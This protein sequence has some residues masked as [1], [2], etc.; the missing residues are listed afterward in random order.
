MEH[1]HG[2]LPGRIAAGLPLRA[3]AAR[4]AGAAAADGGACRA[5]FAQPGHPAGGGQPGLDE[6][7]A[8]VSDTER[9]ART[10]HHGRSAL[11]AA[12][13]HRPA[14]AGVVCARLHRRDALP[15]LRVVEPGF[16]AGPAQLPG[17]GGAFFRG[18][19]PGVGMVGR[20]RAVRPRLRRH[21]LVVV[22]AGAARTRTRRATYPALRGANACCGPAWR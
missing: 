5:A 16:D 7:G 19:G 22:A 11:P 20:L 2:V 4:D 10:G 17:A 6:R 9:A 13:D 15:P 8:S 12:V 1:L 14:H 18:A 21:R 3:L